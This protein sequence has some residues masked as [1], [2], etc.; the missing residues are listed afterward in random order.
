MIR[1]V[2]LSLLPAANWWGV[3]VNCPMYCKFRVAHY[4]DPSR[5]TLCGV[6]WA[7][8][9]VISRSAGFAVMGR[10]L[11]NSERIHNTGSYSGNPT[12]VC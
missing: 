9:R 7:C 8:N 12:D 4:I 6:N 1:Y 11:H 5:K 2:L 10:G 3:V